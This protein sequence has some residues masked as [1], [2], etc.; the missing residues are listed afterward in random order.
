MIGKQ[1][2]GEGRKDLSGLELGLCG[3]GEGGGGKGEGEWEEG[4]E[5]ND[6]ELMS[7]I[8]FMRFSFQ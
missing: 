8:K 1:E 5:E 4:G 2:R 7:T 6:V 3:R